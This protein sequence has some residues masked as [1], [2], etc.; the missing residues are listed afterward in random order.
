MNHSRSRGGYTLIE[1][2]VSLSVFAMVVVI[3]SA[4]YLSFIA[5]NR[6][7]QTSATIIN[8]L[9]FSIDRMA[10]DIRTGTG[11]ACPG[12]ICSSSGVSSLTFTD[13]AGCTVTY[14]LS[15]TAIN[16]SVSGGG[17]ACPVEATGA[18]TDSSVSVSSF[19]FY[20]RG[21]D[22]GDDTQPMA[23][24]VV[25]GSACVPN[26]D[27]TGNGLIPFDIETSATE[28]F[29][30]IANAAGGVG[31]GGSGGSGGPTCS[32]SISPQDGLPGAHTLTW[33]TSNAT[34]LSIACPAG[35]D[36]SSPSCPFTPTPVSGGSMTVRPI[37]C[38]STT[39]TGTV[40]GTGGSGTC[41]VTA[42]VSCGGP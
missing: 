42:A 32:L 24:M 28:R 17:S 38:P 33:S 8:S 20:V 25:K 14:S 10:R 1:L 29:P 5:Y 12:G 31:S 22:A 16:R 21:L 3:A 11:Y 37:L 6:Q 15:G 18:I 27:C 2:L 35:S 34:S 9:S 39:Y 13:T 36:G 23:T 4:A 40:T 30:D 26:T 41:S 7:A 19:L